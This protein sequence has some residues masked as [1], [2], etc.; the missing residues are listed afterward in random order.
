MSFLIWILRCGFD[1]D[2]RPLSGTGRLALV[3]PR[4]SIPAPDRLHRNTM[5]RAGS[6]RCRNHALCTKGADGSVAG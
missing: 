5:E 6:L 1:D 4:P 2:I 3:V